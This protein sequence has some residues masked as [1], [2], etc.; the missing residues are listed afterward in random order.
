MS[1][2]IMEAHEC[3]EWALESVKWLCRKHFTYGYALGILWSLECLGKPCIVPM[4]VRW[5]HQLCGGPLG[6]C[7]SVLQKL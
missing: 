7:D 3:P 6:D 4:S 5:G 2:W 1:W